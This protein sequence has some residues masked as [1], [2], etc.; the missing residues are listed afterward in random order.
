MD[1]PR[2]SIEEYERQRTVAEFMEWIQWYKRDLIRTDEASGVESIER[3]SLVGKMMYEEAHPISHYISSRT[4]PEES[5]IRLFSGSQ[6]F[7]G[8]VL[9]ADQTIMHLEVTQAI[10]QDEHKKRQ[11]LAKKGFSC[12]EYLTEYSVLSGRAVDRIR[13]RIAAKVAKEYPSGTVL[14]VPIDDDYIM[15]DDSIFAACL[16]S[17]GPVEHGTAF[18]EI[19]VC[20]HNGTL[21]ATLRRAQQGG[22]PDAFGAGYL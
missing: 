20:S 8:Q 3:K 4:F 21:C 16:A 1:H 17:I 15:S 5:T 11:A 9:L 6:N 19:F 10:D 18:H 12:P 13:E 2:I 14:I 22:Q 7:D